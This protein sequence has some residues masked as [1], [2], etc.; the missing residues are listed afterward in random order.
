VSGTPITYESA[1]E[2]VRGWIASETRICITVEVSGVVL[3]HACGVLNKPARWDP[4]QDDLL[5]EA[6]GTGTR[7]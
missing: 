6:I 2:A 3:V 1:T 7:R 4:D 5:L